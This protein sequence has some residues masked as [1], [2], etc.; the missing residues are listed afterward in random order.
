MIPKIHTREDKELKDVLRL[1]QG[2]FAYMD[3]RIDPPSSMHTLSVE[4]I[5]DQCDSG[6]VWTLGDPIIACMFLRPEDDCLYLGKVA[7]SESK[8]G[9]GI[10]RLMIEHAAMRAVLHNKNSLELYTRIELLE[11][12]L[13]FSKL[14]FKVVREA[15][16]QGYVKPTFLIMRKLI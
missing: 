3:G 12:H 10:G 14:G 5:M 2:S 9:R 13:V 1:I 8:R 6:E 7:V 16:H 11:N 15:S 4:D